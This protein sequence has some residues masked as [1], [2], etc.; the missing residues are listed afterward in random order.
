MKEILALMGRSGPR[1]ERIGY[2]AKSV[3]DAFDGV[4]P[5][6]CTYHALDHRDSLAGAK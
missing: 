4:N 5:W 2:T 1:I 6:S 3:H